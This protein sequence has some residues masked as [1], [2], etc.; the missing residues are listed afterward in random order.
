M[1][2]G[3]DASTKPNTVTTTAWVKR[4]DTESNDQ[5]IIDRNS[6]LDRG[7]GYTLTI[8]N[9]KLYWR[10][11]D[12]D[13]GW[14]INIYTPFSDT[15]WHHIIGVYDSNGAFLYVDSAQKANDSYKG[16]IAY[17]PNPLR[18]GIMSYADI[19]HFNGLI[20]EVLIFNSALSA[21][22]VQALYEMTKP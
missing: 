1:D 12:L 19:G 13:S 20:D 21:S 4:A 17:I 14:Y 2:C 10:L 16:A 6:P 15:N 3:D 7:Y 11:R 8:E 9:N 18:I 5:Y 22:D